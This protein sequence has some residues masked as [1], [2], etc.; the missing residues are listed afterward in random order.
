MKV[1]DGTITRG[2]D[3]A[4][5]VF[6]INDIALTVPPTN[7]SIRKEDMVWQWKTLRTNASTKIPSGR[8]IVQVSVR[9]IFV[10]QHFLEMHRLIT[11]FKHSPFCYIEN[12][13]IRDSIVPDWLNSQMMA[14]TM[15]GLNVQNMTGSPGTFI[16]D[17]DLRWFNYAPYAINWLY[18]DEYATKPI[19]EEGAVR[20]I[21]T[22]GP[23]L[24][25]M[26]SIIDFLPK[27]SDAL[28][29]YEVLSETKDIVGGFTMSDLLF[30]HA[31]T[32]FDLLPRPT[33]VMRKAKP[34]APHLSN[35]YKRY[36]NTLQQKAL[37]HNFNVDI[38]K[39][40][41]DQEPTLA[42]KRAVTEEEVAGI[43]ERFTSETVTPDAAAQPGGLVVWEQFT[44]GI[45]KFSTTDSNG[46]VVGINVVDSL[47]SNALPESVRQE[48]IFECLKFCRDATFVWHQYIVDENDPELRKAVADKLSK[49]H[50]AVAKEHSARARLLDDLATATTSTSR[51][52]SYTGPIN[53]KSIAGV[54]H[55]KAKDVPLSE[56]LSYGS[57]KTDL[58]ELIPVKEMTDFLDANPVEPPYLFSAVVDEVS[59]FSGFG[60]RELNGDIRPHSGI[61]IKSPLPGKVYA[62]FDGTLTIRSANPYNTLDKGVGPGVNTVTGNNDREDKVGENS[63]ESHLRRIGLIRGSNSAGIHLKLV[64][65][66]FEGYSADFHHMGMIGEDGKVGDT[67]VAKFYTDKSDGDKYGGIEIVQE[68]IEVKRGQ[69]IGHWGNTG[70]SAGPHLHFE[71]RRDGIAYD[72]LPFMIARDVSELSE[73]E[74]YDLDLSSEGL[75]TNPWRM[76]YEHGGTSAEE[77][78]TTESYGVLEVLEPETET[79]TTS[80]DVVIDEELKKRFEEKEIAYLA[81]GFVPY[82]DMQDV[83]NVRKRTVR[84]SFF[85]ENN[86]FHPGIVPDFVTERTVDM[87]APDDQFDDTHVFSLKG[88]DNMVITNVVASLSHVVASIP[89]LGHEFPT[90]QHLGSIEPSYTIEFVTQAD[91]LFNDNLSAEG[92]LLELMRSTL[93]RNARDFRPIPDGYAVATDHFITR[94]LGSYKQEDV[95]LL[96]VGS[97]LSNVE[98]VLKRTLIN[99]VSTQTVDGH[100]GLSS[101]Q[102][103]LVETNPYETE[104]LTIESN[105]SED[106]REELIKEV[107][108]R[109]Y[110]QN[111]TPEGKVQSIVEE[112][113]TDIYTEEDDIAAKLHAAGWGPED[114]GKSTWDEVKEVAVF[115]ASNDFTGGETIQVG[116]A[117][118]TSEIETGGFG[119]GSTIGEETAWEILRDLQEA[120]SEADTALYG[121]YHKPIED[122]SAAASAFPTRGEA[123]T[124]TDFFVDMTDFY[125]VYPELKPNS[126]SGMSSTQLDITAKYKGLKELLRSASLS[127]GEQDIGLSSPVVTESF[128]GL[129]VEQEM[130]SCFYYFF[131]KYLR[132]LSGAVNFTDDSTDLSNSVNIMGEGVQDFLDAINWNFNYKEPSK[133]N[134]DLID[135]SIEEMVSEGFDLSVAIGELLE[136]AAYDDTSISAEQ[137]EM[138]E[139][140]KSSV[141]ELAEK[142]IETFMKLSIDKESLGMLES[143]WADIVKMTEG[144]ASWFSTDPEEVKQL[145]AYDTAAAQIDYLLNWL[146]SPDLLGQ[147]DNQPLLHLYKYIKSVSSGA[148]LATSIVWVIGLVLGALSLLE[149]TPAG[150]GAAVAGTVATTTG[151]RAAASRLAT[152]LAEK[153]FLKTAAQ[154]VRSKA[155]QQIALS[156][157]AAYGGGSYAASQLADGTYSETDEN[158]AAYQF[159]VNGSATIPY[160]SFL[161]EETEAQKVAFYRK[162]LNQ[163]AESIISNPALLA[164]LGV[165]TEEY[166]LQPM[167]NEWVGTPCYPDLDLPEHPYYI[168]THSYA[169]SPDFYM[170]SPY[171]DGTM[172]IKDEIKAIVERGVKTVVD[173]SYSF[174][175]Q[176]QEDGI[177]AVRDGGMELNNSLGNTT[178]KILSLFSNPEGVDKA[179]LMKRDAEIKSWKDSFAP[180]D[181]QMPD[182]ST[183]VWDMTDVNTNAFRADPLKEAVTWNKLLEQTGSDVLGMKF[184]KA[185]SDSKDY[186]PEGKGV[187]EA[188][189]WVEVTKGG[190]TFTAVDNMDF[191]VQ[192][193]DTSTDMSVYDQYVKKVQNIS[194]MFGSRQGYLGDE[195]T[196]DNAGELVKEVA[197]TALASLSEAENWYTKGGIEQV[198]KHSSAD[199]VSEKMTLKRAYPTFKLYFVEEDEQESRWLNLDDF[200]SFNAVKEFNFYQSRKE[201]SSTATIVLQNIAG[202]LDGTRRSAIV[203]LDYFSRKKA[204]EIEEDKGVEVLA[205]NKQHVA[206]KDQPFDA[207][208]LRPG[209]NVQLRVG[210]SNDPNML[211]VLLNGRVVDVQWNMTGDLTEITVQSFG[212]ELTQT[213]KG[214]GGDDYSVDWQ[215]KVFYTTHQLLGTLMMDRDLKHFGRWEFGRLVQIGEDSNADLDFYPYEEE[216][217]L[218]GMPA[219]K[220]VYDLFV[221]HPW[222]MGL[223]IGAISALIASKGR[224]S[225]L[226]VGTSF[227][228]RT[229]LK[230]PV[231][232]L[233]ALARWRGTVIGVEGVT[234]SARAISQARNSAEIWKALVLEGKA[235]KAAIDSLG[236]TNVALKSNIDKMVA[237]LHG[238]SGAARVKQVARLRGVSSGLVNA[239]AGLI[240]RGGQLV[241]QTNP[242]GLQASQVS[243]R[244][245]TALR[246]EAEALLRWQSVSRWMYYP[247]FGFSQFKTWAGF[248]SNAWALGK[249]TLGNMAIK[250]FTNALG[251]G[252]A[253]VVGAGVADVVL[254]YDYIKEH[255]R[256][257]KNRTKRINARLKMTPAD[258]N[259]FAPSPASYMTL[260]KIADMGWTRKIGH[261]MNELVA[262]TLGVNVVSTWETV[263]RLWDPQAIDPELFEKRVLPTACQYILH[264][265]TIWE[266]FEE[267]TLRHPGWIWGTRPYGTEFRDTMFFGTPSQRYWSRPASSAFVLR[268]NKLYEYIQRTGETEELIKK[269]I[270]EVYG[271]DVIERMLEEIE[272]P[273][274]DSHFDV[275]TV[276]PPIPLRIFLRDKFRVAL[277][278]EWLKGMEQRFEPFRR[279]HLITSERDIISNNIICSE[280]SVVN[281]A[282]VVHSTMNKLGQI[283]EQEKSVL[284]MK[285]HSLIPDHM[286]NT[287]VVDKHNCKSYKMALR[288]GQ[289]AMMYGLKE[290]YKGEIS[291]LGNPRIRPW[292][293]C[294]LA[295]SYNDM[296]GPVEVESVVHMFS[297]ETGFITEIKPNALVIG[298]EIATYPI[299]EAM[300][301]YAMAKVD[302]ENNEVLP[303]G[304]RGNSTVE[305]TSQMQ[306]YFNKRYESIFSEEADA[307][308]EQL[309]KA[310]DEQKYLSNLGVTIDKDD[311]GKYPQLSETGIKWT[312]GKGVAGAALT[313]AA[314]VAAATGAAKIPQLFNLTGRGAGLAKGITGG[315][316]GIAGGTAVG[317]VALPDKQGIIQ[318]AAGYIGTKLLF[319]K[320]MEQET[321]MVIPLLKGRRPVVAGM[322]LKNPSD[323]FESILGSVTNVMEDAVMGTRDMFDSWQD[324]KTASWMQVDDIVTERD[325]FLRK[326]Y[327]EYEIFYNWK[328]DYRVP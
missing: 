206:S 201:A 278:D 313:V 53:T 92:A 67:Q 323:V 12:A 217:F 16:V 170:W 314:G 129:P 204:G 199:I 35:I 220:W 84:Y 6:V 195:I 144:V 246:V 296:S 198:V 9:L 77:D 70:G 90:H 302:L 232:G 134:K 303:D 231:P 203:D 14:F 137:A 242:L 153:Q 325:N 19:G 142:Y 295:D 88:S 315:L 3:E 210:Y 99:R 36:I 139:D 31:G 233:R 284:Q 272:R 168:G 188:E 163:L 4:D 95:S 175:K 47:H 301:L 235:G 207:I 241:P 64:S 289:A 216:G 74:I 103:S 229:A 100:P 282:Q 38:A 141:R 174:M 215:D 172:A 223:A 249:V 191:N 54:T 93:Q 11:Q 318:S 324:Y 299:L 234:N 160:E 91:S 161:N 15:T 226:F 114:F 157:G 238:L 5:S 151:I 78:P 259:I 125:T 211:H 58:L 328:Q 320:C 149:P 245:G 240:T 2:A 197:D 269:Q 123:S 21:E 218:G 65:S 244:L 43:D 239:E 127:I 131:E 270:T 22:Y 128:Y 312:V 51:P 66:S 46:E 260:R 13:L 225:R 118:T 186:L 158:T 24:K 7:I 75:P 224:A 102:V 326:A 26:S 178:P 40:V 169:M 39:L 248:K 143:V 111:L 156:A 1:F 101:I 256:G 185:G 135:A 264:A 34:V 255:I 205:D 271:T 71:V 83:S 115:T 285:A 159:L 18:R 69:L 79:G 300:K 148:F 177:K 181:F 258:D 147:I 283:K 105:S 133:E 247:R 124:T 44:T 250:P 280:H 237:A 120:A 286:L 98:T 322:T 262:N 265:S 108:H 61:D 17:L 41:R 287:A 116:G 33:D 55:T 253:A 219:T 152:Y 150:E 251:V 20:T 243:S 176:M 221:N 76:D 227:T 110:N 45:R 8:G 126:A 23:G 59:N 122:A 187:R 136:F 267:M 309:N 311:L 202:T 97:E 32:A 193:A 213:R 305:T 268:M 222:K 167:L 179:K 307:Y 190:P 119:A 30:N 293:V 252:T 50:E 113:A 87:P 321:I 37:F 56:R 96:K 138:M 132:E 57:E 166:T 107:L 80:P 308:I 304:S 85:S 261:T 180:I 257:I 164:A 196:K 292:D 273:F 42:T 28:D 319:A 275:Q 52:S 279:Y 277:M 294:I 29:S 291:L 230:V 306:A 297:H 117:T 63:R 162:K 192:Y 316:G 81:E 104:E 290:M 208:V 189:T 145:T 254:P 68:S 73:R 154:G 266:V 60:I 200:Y 281:A 106:E 140:F 49:D 112:Y 155:G 27:A 146:F 182:G 310:I 121:K 183:D 72:P 109:L 173:N 263:M 212:T 327:T 214:V 62:P 94:L 165:R 82:E 48:V 274:F 89:I 194:D 298:N 25:K 288:Y 317:S 184:E 10:P 130:M 228:S 86:N 171:E 209:M 236:A 276:G